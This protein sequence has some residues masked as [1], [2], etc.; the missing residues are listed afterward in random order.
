MPGAVM[1][2]RND[3]PPI[4]HIID[5]MSAAYDA[6]FTTFLAHTDQKIRARE[7]LA[8]VVGRLPRHRALI[9]AG[10]WT[11]ETTAWLAPMFDRTIA[12]EPNEHMRTELARRCPE[13]TV[14]GEDIAVAEP[15]VPADLVLCAHVL[16]YLPQPSWLPQLQR[17]ASWTAEGGFTVVVLQNPDS[18]C[19]RL[20]RRFTGHRYDL[21]A[22]GRAFAATAGAEWDV[23]ISTDPAFITMPD[24]DTALTI[25]QFMLNVTPLAHAPVMDEVA[26]YLDEHFRT[27]EGYRLSCDQDFLEL[28]HN[29]PDE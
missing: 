29:G 9:D 18:D 23:G 17:L 15:D 24:L 19:M 16:Y 1:T 13:A 22:L 10:A 7:E 21:D 2:D 8:R 20:L 5:P 26:A 4:V 3:E 28:Q 11:G 25:A 14:L 12:I 27:P 6:A